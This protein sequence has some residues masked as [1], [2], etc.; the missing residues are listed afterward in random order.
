MT[1]SQLLAHMMSSRFTTERSLRHTFGMDWVEPM[2]GLMDLRLVGRAQTEWVIAY[3]VRSVWV[4][5]L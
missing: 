3:Y 4:P 1:R 5:Q 2:R